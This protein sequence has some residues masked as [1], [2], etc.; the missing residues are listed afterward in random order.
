[1]L[2]MRLLFASYN[3]SF[4]L[5]DSV[6]LNFLNIFDLIRVL[7]LRLLKF[8]LNFSQIAF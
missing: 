5:F 8:D 6:V 1:M 4:T 3:D 2:D 7:N